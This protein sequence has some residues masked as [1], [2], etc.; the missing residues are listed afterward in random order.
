MS[1]STRIFVTHS[2]AL[3]MDFGLREHDAGGKLCHCEQ[4][5][6]GMCKCI[7]WFNKSMNIGDCS[8]CMCASSISWTIIHFYIQHRTDFKYAI[9]PGRARGGDARRS[10]FRHGVASPFFV[11]R[12][13]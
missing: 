7:D 13:P 3:G 10:L 6:F 12:P 2:P 4:D 9:R 5:S 1:D 11:L 8:H